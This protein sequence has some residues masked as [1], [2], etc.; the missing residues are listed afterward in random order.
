[1]FYDN[2]SFFRSGGFNPNNF[3]FAGS[4]EAR[5][6]VGAAQANAMG[7]IGAAQWGAMGQAFQ[8]PGQFA[9]AFA[10]LNNT[11]G[12]AYGGY[13]GGMGNAYGSYA[14]GLGNLATAA[15]Y[16][17]SN[18]Y[19]SQAMAEAA[20]MGALGNIGSA[21]LGAYGSA[22]NAAL[23]AWAQNQ[24]A[25]N[26]AAAGMHMANQ[27]GLSNYGA[28]NAAAQGNAAA[29]SAAAAGQV[30]AA[31]ANAMGQIGRAQVA[32]NA[33]A[34]LGLGGGGGGS[35][36]AGGVEGPIGS[37][38]FSGLGIPPVRG[39]GSP[40]LTE[41]DVFGGAYGGGGG[42]DINDPGIVAGLQDNARAGRRQIDDQH[43][44]SRNMPSDMMGQSLSGLL[45]LTQQSQ[46][47][48]GAGMN[49]FYGTQQRAA[50]QAMR[51]FN[52]TRGA[53]GS[54]FGEVTQGLERGFGSV[55]DMTRNMAG[56]IQ[57]LYD[58]AP[59]RNQMTTPAEQARMQREAD[60]LQ[61][62]Y[63]EQ[64]RLARALGNMGDPRRRMDRERW[65]QA[66]IGSQSRLNALAG[67]A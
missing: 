10:N 31:R 34:G 37:G 19:G 35:F 56:S 58:N 63:A 51:Q 18:L 20:R 45:A 60:L 17:R 40:M 29:A 4:P 23:N 64:D 3:T 12:N 67:L 1:M 27:S 9:N 24:S 16:E 53:L 43:Y 22:S 50:D 15:A 39:G 32:G 54:G 55:G 6:V 52:A 48:I 42:V 38:S 11:Y 47:A 36:L 57:G 13:A 7:Q 28:A 41:S 49:Q 30:G 44:S 26:Q 25:Y 46:G 62:R 2:N 33:L 5:G 14:T 59:W 21:G 66:A 8:Q 61:N 65:R